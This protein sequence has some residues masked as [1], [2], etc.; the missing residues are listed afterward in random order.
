MHPLFQ[1]ISGY[2]HNLTESTGPLFSTRGHKGSEKFVNVV[3]FEQTSS[4]KETTITLCS[5]LDFDIDTSYVDNGFGSYLELFFR[6]V[7][8][9]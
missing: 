3:V 5:S 1:S 6:S 8:T 4:E 2:L 9:V 7:R